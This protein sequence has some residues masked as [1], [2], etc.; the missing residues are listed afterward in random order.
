MLCLVRAESERSLIG[1]FRHLYSPGALQAREAENVFLEILNV[2]IMALKE[3]EDN[4]TVSSTKQHDD[5]TKCL[6]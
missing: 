4:F 5:H 6:T 2:A 3:I 1:Q